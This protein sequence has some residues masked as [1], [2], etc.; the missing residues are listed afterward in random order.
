MGVWTKI[1]RRFCRHTYSDNLYITDAERRGEWIA[2]K[3][4]KCGKIYIFKALG[5]ESLERD[6]RR[7]YNK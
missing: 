7:M 1:K 2:N 5:G 3:C 6:I 4:A